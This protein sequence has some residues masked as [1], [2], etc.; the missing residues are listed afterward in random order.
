MLQKSKIDA[1]KSRKD[2]CFEVTSGHEYESAT[3][4]ACAGGHLIDLRT[5]RA[6]GCD[7]NQAFGPVFDRLLTAPTCVG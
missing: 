5:G 7:D 3:R 4:F 6:S 2:D 1:P